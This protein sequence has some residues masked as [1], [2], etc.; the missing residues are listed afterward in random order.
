MN[1]QPAEVT[2]GLRVAKRV[3]VERLAFLLVFLLSTLSIISYR[4]HFF[5]R[6]YDSFIIKQVIPSSGLQG[7][8][9][10]SFAFDPTKYD[11]KQ[12][13][14]LGSPYF[15][16][17]DWDDDS[18]L[19]STASDY[20]GIWY[21]TREIINGRNPYA[22]S[23]GMQFISHGKYRKFRWAREV[24]DPSVPDQFVGILSYPPMGPL[25]ILPFYLPNYFASYALYL[26]VLHL[27]MVWLAFGLVKRSPG[28]RL[29]VALLATTMF[30]TSYPL[31]FLV[32]R[33]NIEGSVFI[34]ITCGIIAYVRG[35]YLASA[36]LL[37]LAASGKVVPAIFLA[38]FL[39]DGR[40]K[41]LAVSIM[42]MCGATLLALLCMHEPLGSLVPQILG[43]MNE[44]KFEVGNGILPTRFDHSIFGMLRGLLS[45][46]FHKDRATHL[47]GRLSP[48]YTVAILAST[49]LILYFLRRVSITNRVLVLTVLML[50][51]PQISQDYKLIHLYIPFGMILLGVMH[52]GWASSAEGATLLILGVIFSPKAYQ[53]GDYGLGS[54]INGSLLVALIIIGLRA[55]LGNDESEGT[56]L[57]P[58]LS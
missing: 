45:L 34:L 23:S 38:L 41:A 50:S 57:M 44:A 24:E 49:A 55:R 56:R 7:W 12:R 19:N 21:Y 40:Y 27:F 33:G 15:P 37:G 35:Y 16:E 48:F 32:D 17:Y 47:L 18:V 26:L 42:T 51:F 43:H 11:A 6:N 8:L 4:F 5:A 28:H 30:L 29:P 2:T 31:G 52:K 25:L 58:S 10:R 54:W 1:L 39:L 36:I 14:T 13:A 20:L 22:I 46:I 3:G 53:V 9:S